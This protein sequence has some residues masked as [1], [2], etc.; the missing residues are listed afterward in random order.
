MPDFKKIRSVGAELLRAEG[1]ADM[2]KL[3]AALHNFS[4]APIKI[5]IISK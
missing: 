4:N 5:I 1:Q 2:M 3:L